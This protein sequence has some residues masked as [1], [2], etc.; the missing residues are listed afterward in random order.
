M[1]KLGLRSCSGPFDWYLFD[2]WAVI[3]QI[4]CKFSDFLNPINAYIPKPLEMKYLFYVSAELVEYC[5]AA[6]DRSV[7]I[8]NKQFDA[9]SFERKGCFCCYR[10][11]ERV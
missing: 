2:Y 4:K 3:E 8:K 11:K 1:R 7:I 10:G 9:V 5:S 6:L